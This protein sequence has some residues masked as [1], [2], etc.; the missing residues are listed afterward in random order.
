MSKR[1]VD[2]KVADGKVTSI[3]GNEVGGGTAVEANPQEPATQQ[4]EK[5]KIDNIA[6][7]I[8]GGGSG[9]IVVGLTSGAITDGTTTTESWSSATQMLPNT[10]YQIGDN[11]QLYYEKRFNPVQLQPNQ[12]I[13]IL[14]TYAYSSANDRKLQYGDVVMVPTLVEIKSSA[15]LSSDRQFRLYGTYYITYTVI[16][17]GTTGDSVNPPSESF[18][19]GAKYLKYTFESA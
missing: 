7:N 15:S 14:D 8:A 19:E 16:K 11:F 1:M 4:L 12:T 18:D 5:I 3:N 17:A 9:G 13:S 10:A 6:Y 2:L